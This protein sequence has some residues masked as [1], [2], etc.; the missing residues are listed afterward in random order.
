MFEKLF[1]SS[2]ASAILEAFGRSQAIIEFTPDGTIVNANPNF[3]NAVG[4]R[5]EEVKG[6]HHSIFVNKDYAR[7]SEYKDFWRK[8]GSGEF[9][10][11]EYP[12]FTKDGTEIWIQ[13]SYN[14][15]LSSSGKVTGVVKIASDI[16]DAKRK[17]ADAAG[18]LDAIN[19]SQAVIH[20]ELDGTIIDANDNF[21]G[22]M[23]YRREEIVGKHHS[24]FGEPSLVQSQEYKQFWNDLRSGQF[25]GGEFKRVAKGGRE[26]WIQATYNPILDPK[27]KPFKVVKFATDI[28]DMVK[29]R[30]RRQATQKQIDI[31]LDEVSHRIQDA[32]ERSSVSASASS[33]AAMSVQTVAAASEE[34]VASIAEIGRQVQLA[35]EVARKA[36]DEADQS[37]QIMAGLSADAQEI[38]T[39]I[40]LIDSIANQTN[41][42]ALNATIEAA[43]AG[44]A[45]KGFAVVAS[46][47]KSLASQTTKATEDIG[48]QIASVQNTAGQAVTAIE[49]IMEIINQING[50]S[51][52][53]S[54]AVQQQE[55]ASREISS[56]MQSAAENVDVVNTNMQSISE[57]ARDIEMKTKTVKEASRMIA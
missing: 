11:G 20:F 52:E 36:V 53:I 13:A 41:L 27:G 47:V 54:A 3:L 49:T 23:G 40:E 17:A 43:R 48:S 34:L 24:M 1:G 39:V 31:D 46:E 29:D 56:N 26:I 30:M 25:K 57:A 18:Q 51:S 6:K 8:L 14:P 45:G 22:A 15:I 42:L 32:A 28:T 44:E 12:R 55:A 33:Q 2:N 4:Y 9:D 37:N 38:G 7:S 19:R 21:L 16:T 35:G 5:L 50:I 10:S